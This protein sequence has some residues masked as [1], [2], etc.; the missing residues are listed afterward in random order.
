[1]KHEDFPR[2]RF[3]R[4]QSLLQ[5]PAHLFFFRRGGVN[6]RFEAVYGFKAGFAA[7]TAAPG[8][9]RVPHDGDKPWSK[10]LRRAQ[11]VQF[12]KRGYEGFLGDVFR[13]RRIDQVASRNG[14]RRRQIPLDQNTEIITSARQHP[15]HHPRIEILPQHEHVHLP[16]RCSP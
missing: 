5:G 3:Q 7:L 16:P 13:V 6:G 4:G 9:R 1:M 10:P 15:A 2:F 14:L 12:L 8:A 11:G